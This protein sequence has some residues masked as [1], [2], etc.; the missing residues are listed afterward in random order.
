MLNPFKS[1]QAAPAADDTPREWITPRT[2]VTALLLALTLGVAAVSVFVNFTIL[3]PHFGAWAVPTLAAL[4]ILWVA[5]QATEILAGNHKPRARRVLWAGV[6]LTGI[7]AAIPTA[8]LILKSTGSGTFDLAVVIVPVAIAAT[9]IAWWLILPSLGRRTS[10]ATRRSIAD[11]RQTLADRLETLEAEGAARVEFLEAAASIRKRVTEAETQYRL[12]V[13]EAE[14]AAH[15]ALKEQATTTNASL[16][17]PLPDIVHA[18][19]LPALGTWDPAAPMALP[20]RP[21]AGSVTPELLPSG[22]GTQVNG[23]PGTIPARPQGAPYTLDELASVAGVPVPAP[24][25]KLS[26]AQIRVVLR[27]LRH[28]TNP[29]GGYRPAN[30]QF[31]KHGFVA[32]EDRLREQWREVLA[33]EG[34]DEE[35]TEDEQQEV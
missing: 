4:D 30:G 21:R 5:F 12:T 13:L 8:D 27:W 17:E 23:G 29:P 1:K 11:S 10:P 7:T 19:E 24:A 18:I 2:A 28:G 32:A 31:R 16:S 34:A 9:K 3:D 35:E 20:S 22:D 33:Q 25:Q 26:D 15:G 14:D 6:V